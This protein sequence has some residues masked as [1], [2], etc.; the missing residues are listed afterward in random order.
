MKPFRIAGLVALSLIFTL[1]CFPQSENAEESTT[2]AVIE[3]KE[4]T[5]A[6]A[7]AVEKF[8]ADLNE[9][10]VWLTEEIWIEDN[11]E[12]RAHRLPIKMN[13]KLAAVST[14]DLPADLVEAF[15]AY[16][17][18]FQKQADHVT[19]MPEDFAEIME[20]MAKK[21]EDEAFSE[22]QTALFEAQ[23]EAESIFIEV[24][25]GYGAGTE[26]YLYRSDEEV[27]ELKEMT[28]KE[29]AA[30]ETF[31]AGL[32]EIHAW[33]AEEVF[34]EDNAEARSHRLPIIMSTKLAAVPTE[35]LPAD[36]IEAFDAYKAIVQKQADLVKGMPKDFA[37]IME[38]MAK[39]FEDEAFFEA[40]SGLF[41]AQFEA[42]VNLI[43]VASSYGA[44]TEAD[45]YRSDDGE[46]DAP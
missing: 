36:L 13:A 3:L 30:V 38:F 14:E 39:K 7:A 46:G 45:L 43:N 41:D 42:E 23:F 33:L 4:M 28:E 19:G 15:D 5:E 31:K 18:V 24:A 44:G 29:A 32:N 16:K 8:K 2:E 40:Q 17:A 37:A 22:A 9:I 34:V 11:A 20:F 21:F 26:A 12:A 27:I 6:E 35:G 25:S 1:P 10:H